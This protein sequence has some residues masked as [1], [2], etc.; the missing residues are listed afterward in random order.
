MSRRLRSLQRD[1]LA[2]AG[3]GGLT[4]S[5]RR[6][7]AEGQRRIELT[8]ERLRGRRVSMLEEDEFDL[9]RELPGVEAAFES[10]KQPQAETKRT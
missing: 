2:C 6:E 7:E 5:I 8:L 1:I 10:A 9:L 3:E 4:I